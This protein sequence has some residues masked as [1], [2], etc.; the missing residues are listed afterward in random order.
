MGSSISDGVFIDGIVLTEGSEMNDM[1][2]VILFK[3]FTCLFWVSTLPSA[4]IPSHHKRN[5]G[6]GMVLT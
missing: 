6:C 4:P 2:R 3:Q 5:A 1:S